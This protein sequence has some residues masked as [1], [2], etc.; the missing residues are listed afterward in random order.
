MTAPPVVTFDVFSA[1]IDSRTG[2]SAALD[3]IA[4]DRGWSVGG[5][6]IYD[7]WDALNKQSQRECGEW[8]SYADLARAALGAAYASLAVEGDSDALAADDVV[9][10]LESMPDWPLW[11]DVAAGL[12]ALAGRFRVGLLS[13]IDDNLLAGTRVAA[14]VDVELALTS[15]RLRA[16]KPSPRIYREARRRLGPMIH[17]ATSGRDVRGALEAGLTVVRLERPGHALDP[18]GPRPVHEAT[19][20]AELTVPLNR[21]VPT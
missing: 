14:L 16:Y 4:R 7:R 13:N 15:E 9:T 1:L 21:A 2:G 5:E 6:E 19:D 11:P 20:I 18:D 10:L 8:V 3:G 12:P 17:V